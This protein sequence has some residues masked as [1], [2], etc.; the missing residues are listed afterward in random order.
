VTAPAPAWLDPAAVA[1]W[2]KQTV[3][4]AADLELLTMCCAAAEPPVESARPDMWVSVPSGDPDIPP[5]RVYTPDGEVLTA[6]IMLAGKIYRRRNSP[7]G[8]ETSF[9]QV[10]N[11]VARYDPEIERALHQ[12]RSRKPRVD[13]GPAAVQYAGI[14]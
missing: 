1:K 11:Y 9:D 2:L 4:S 10:V 14:W 8:M 5:G 12:G 3:V 13:A 7:G 6:G